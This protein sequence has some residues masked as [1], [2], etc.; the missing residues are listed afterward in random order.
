MSTSNNG[1]FTV[2]P[3][4]PGWTV[5]IGEAD[6]HAAATSGRY[7]SST[8]L[9]EFQRCP[10]HYSELTSGKTIRSDSDAM[11]FGRAAHALLMEGEKAFH[12]RY[13]IGGPFNEKTGRSYGPG[14][15]I[16]GEWLNDNGLQ[17]KS[18][19]T[20]TE[21]ATLCRMRKALYAHTELSRLL[22]LGWPELSARAE[23]EGVD[24]QARLD[25]LRPDNMAID[26][27]TVDDISRFERDARRFGYLNQFAFYRDV[28]RAAGS[29]DIS[30]I[31]AVV[32]KQPPFRV[33]VWHFS[34]D[35]LEPYSVQNRAD[36]RALLTCK[37]NNRWKTGYEALRE[38]PLAGIPPL[39]LN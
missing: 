27:K 24:C 12:S 19:V 26:M 7:V 23:V 30:M 5:K 15:K 8:M 29:A 22:A 21:Y 13:V 16:F 11:R 2:V 3:F 28:C 6:Y 1:K 18:V 14:T 25:W 33:G 20:N 35:I 34:A 4:I 37:K 10:S 38:F 36:L 9:R 17:R 39:W 32:E 31:A